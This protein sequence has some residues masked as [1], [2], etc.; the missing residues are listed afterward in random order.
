MFFY[1]CYLFSYTPADSTDELAEV[2][3]R[4]AG[5]IAEKIHGIFQMSTERQETQA[6]VKRKQD[7]REAWVSGSQPVAKR[8]EISH[9]V[10]SRGARGGRW[11]RGF[12]GRQRAR[13]G[14][15]HW[16]KSR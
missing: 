1:W 9:R 3:Y 4:M 15:F 16:K 13:G 14:R 11:F 5:K 2:K 6:P 8:V 7:P 10:A 12:R